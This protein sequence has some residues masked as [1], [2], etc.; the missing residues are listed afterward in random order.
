MMMYSTFNTQVGRILF[1]WDIQVYGLK[2][3]MYV[4]QTFTYSNSTI[5]TPEKFVKYVQ[6]K[7]DIR[8]SGVFSV[9][10]EFIPWLYLMFLLLT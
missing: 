8:T 7:Q 4:Y 3:G 2:L 6:S 1:N 5:E 10:F 9:N